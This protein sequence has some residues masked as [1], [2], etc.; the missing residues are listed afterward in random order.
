VSTINYSFTFHGVL[1]RK[2]V[3]WTAKE[4]IDLQ[5]KH[6]NM[7]PEEFFKAFNS[8]VPLGYAGKPEDIGGLV[9]YLVSDD[10]HF[11]TGQTVS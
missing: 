8:E 7:S 3:T 2:L 6:G 9:S 5:A 1:T 11:I 4:F 10:A